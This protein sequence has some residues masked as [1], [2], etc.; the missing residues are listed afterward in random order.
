MDTRER[1][2]N[3]LDKAPMEQKEFAA[4][5]GITDKTA[6]NWRT[7]RSESF[8]KYLPE[9]AEALGTTTEYLLTGKAVSQAVD[10]TL[11]LDP[12]TLAIAQ[13]YK[14]ADERSR[15]MA[16]LALGVDEDLPIAA[17]G[18]HVAKKPSP[19]NAD[20]LDRLSHETQQAADLEN[21]QY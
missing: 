15:T 14:K 7:G 11:C 10:S 13:A 19:S 2:F 1:I 4:K 16:R 8:K 6:S 18:G 17:R 5:I 12:E 3:L 20:T 9:I 21:D